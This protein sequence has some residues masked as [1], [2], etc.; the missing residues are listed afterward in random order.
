MVKKYVYGNPFNTEAVI[1]NISVTQGNPE[2]GKIQTEQGFIFSYK[3]GEKDRVY[4]LGENVR[5]INKR[6]FEY[7]SNC[8]DEPKH[9]ED[10]RSLYGAHNFLVV[11]G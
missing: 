2:Y 9:L 11:D 4:G 6:G 7:I 5:G 10:K 3:L 8:T 1:E